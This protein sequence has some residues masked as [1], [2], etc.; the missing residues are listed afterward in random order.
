MLKGREDERYFK[1][2]KNFHF[3]FSMPSLRNLNGF[4]ASVNKNYNCN[5]CLTLFFISK[6]I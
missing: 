2:F 6:Y 3:L 5:V 1:L 4:F